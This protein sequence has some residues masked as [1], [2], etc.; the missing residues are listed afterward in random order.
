MTHTCMHA[1]LAAT[2]STRDTAEAFVDAL[3]LEPHDLTITRKQRPSN[4]YAMLY[5]RS[6]SLREQQRSSRHDVDG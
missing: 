1:R 2:I 3:R 5:Q 4:T 6:V